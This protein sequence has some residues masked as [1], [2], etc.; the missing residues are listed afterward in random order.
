[1]SGSSS[2]S[3]RTRLTVRWTAVFS[4]ILAAASAS[5]YAGIHSASYADLDRHLRTLAGTEV[6]SAFDQPV[7]PHVHELPTTAL[8]GGTFTEKL[9]QVFDA[10]GAMVV[11]SSGRARQLQFVGD[12]LIAA[13]L[14]GE[15]PVV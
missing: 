10:S 14:R 2:L 11:A 12:D 1:M 3:F 13:A 15:A 9:V 7:S 4:C 8:A 5:I 6:A